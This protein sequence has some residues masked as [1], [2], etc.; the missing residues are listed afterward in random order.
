MGEYVL[1]D[2]HHCWLSHVLRCR[3]W[4]TLHKQETLTKEVLGFVRHSLSKSN[5]PRPPPR[6]IADCLLIVS[7]MI[8]KL[9]QLDDRM[10]IKDKRCVILS[11][12]RIRR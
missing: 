10:L 1:G 3:A 11:V 12:S 5:K 8:G 9:P 2:A 7:M 6:V 4:V